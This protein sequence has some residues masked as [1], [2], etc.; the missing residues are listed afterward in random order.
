[1]A[2]LIANVRVSDVRAN[3]R[4]RLDDFK[5]EQWIPRCRQ[6]AAHDV[7]DGGQVMGGMRED[8]GRDTWQQGPSMIRAN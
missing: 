2:D 7:G 8:R 1:M 4:G 5:A 3:Q 6:L